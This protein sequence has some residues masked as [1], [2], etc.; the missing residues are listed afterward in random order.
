MTVSQI[1]KSLSQKTSIQYITIFSL[2]ALAE[3]RK[4]EKSEFRA[5]IS[6]ADGLLAPLKT[7]N[8]IR[9]QSGSVFVLH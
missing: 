7:R 9:N 5:Q 6:Q 3:R 4:N 1:M 8:R 2:F